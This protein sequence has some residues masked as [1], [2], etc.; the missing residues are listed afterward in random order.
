MQKV[1][2]PTFKSHDGK[3]Y[4]TEK[5]CLYADAEHLIRKSAS[6]TRTCLDGIT[7][8][9]ILSALK[10]DGDVVKE[11]VDIAKVIGK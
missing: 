9:H 8:N 3:I 11:L 5:E 1:E 4:A 7:I 6:F 10:K 2:V